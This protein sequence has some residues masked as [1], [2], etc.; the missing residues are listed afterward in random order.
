MKKLLAYLLMFMGLTL[1]TACGG[2]DDNDDTEKSGSTSLDSIITILETE[3]YELTPRD[4]DSIEYYTGR[5]LT[6]YNI[7]V[8]LKNW[9]VGYIN[10]DERWLE[11]YEFDSLEDAN[12]FYQALSDEEDAGR[13]LYQDGNIVVQTYSAETNALFD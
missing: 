2:S 11:L 8:N 6:D 4:S 9:Q 1:L 5:L 7:T 13:F 10:V 3:G 12:A